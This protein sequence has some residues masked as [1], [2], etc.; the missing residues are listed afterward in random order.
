M[1]VILKLNTQTMKIAITSTGDNREA[2]L[3]SRFGRCSFLVIYDTDNRTTEFIPN[4]SKEHTEGA[5]PAT[6]QLVASHG[7]GKVV[8]GEFG[9]K[10]KS[11]F[12][13]LMIQLIVFPD[14]DK[15]VGEIIEMIKS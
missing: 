5:G 2:K 6:A 9:G 4:T 13:S 14:A 7:V 8:S 1:F 12:E 3:D 10:V 11:I 15:S